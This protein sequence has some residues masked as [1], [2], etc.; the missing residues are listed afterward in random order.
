[1]RFTSPKGKINR[2]LGLAV[3]ENRGAVK[4]LE[5][6]A[7][8]P[9]M[10]GQ[11][12]AKMSEHALA[13]IEKKKVKH[14]Y[15]LHERQL[16]RFYRLAAKS[17]ENTGEVLLVLCERRLDS[18]VRR[19]GFARTRPQARQGVCHGHFR[20][21]GRKVDVASYLVKPGDVVSVAPRT[22]LQKYYRQLLTEGLHNAD[23]LVSDPEALSFTVVRLP[24]A[25][26]VSLPVDVQKVI[27]LLSR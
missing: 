18:V 7:Y 19:A 4:A 14:Y 21:N 13:M 22:A 11:R 17:P 3:Y 25:A 9:G 27:E 5:K 8:K 1:M 26:E 23:W 24:A 15:G 16:E 2:A 10:H 6:R 20:V 12:R